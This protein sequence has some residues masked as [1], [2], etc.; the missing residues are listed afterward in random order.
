MRHLSIAVI[1]AA[2]AST[3]FVAQIATA[4]D[5]PVKALRYAPAPPP[6]VYNWTGFNVG[7][8]IGGGWGSRDVDYSANDANA[9]GFLASGFG[10]P[11][12]S[13]DT[14]GVLGGLQFGY[15]WQFNRNWLVGLEADF[16]WSSMKGSST[17]SKLVLGAL[18][19]TA[20]VDEQI[21]WFG[22]VRARLGYLPT[23]N[24]LAYVTGG[25]AYGKVE[26]SGSY[27]NNSN[28]LVGAIIAP[29][30]LL[31]APFATCATGATS[32]VAT[33]WTVGGGLEYAVWQN[34]TLKAEYLYVSLENKSVTENVIQAPGFGLPPA[35][36]SAN[37]G[38]TNFN[39]ARVGVNYRF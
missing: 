19:F 21:K 16:D 38:R 25:F 2:S 17:T 35:S 26:H 28:N 18:P 13:F 34:W 32:D 31:C 12:T 30:Q 7:A 22:T 1:A 10:P 23:D 5:I 27:V 8:N 20:A 29:F 11:P 39:V 33:G 9:A 37:F 36:F 6:P 15:N 4:A 14:S 3:V 24:L